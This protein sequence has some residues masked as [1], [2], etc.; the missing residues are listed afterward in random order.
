MELTLNQKQQLSQ[1]Q[2][3]SIEI[4]QLS[5][6]ELEQYLQTLAEENP[7][8]ELEPSAPVEDSAQTD[9]VYRR[10]EWL[11]END[12][13]NRCYRSA[14][15]EELEPFYQVG[16][17]GGLEETLSSF[18][19]R[20]LERLHLDRSTRELVEYLIYCLDEDGYFRVPLAELAQELGVPMIRLANAL[21]ILRSL[22]PAGVGAESLAQCLELQL[23]RA[24]Y[25]GPA[26]DIVRYH[27]DSLSRHHYREIA[28][29]LNLS[30]EEVHAAV[31]VIRDLEPKPGGI[32][33]AEEP[34]LYIQPDIYV[35]EVEGR[36]TVR[37]RQER[38]STFQISDY[39]R[40]LYAESPDA[41]TK[42]YLTKKLRQADYVL[43]ALQRR[44]STI[45]RCA[46]AIVDHQQ[47]FF[48]QGTQALHPLLMGDIARELKL[49]ESTVSRAIREKYLQCVH[50]V[51]PLRCFF[52]NS[53]V[54]TAGEEDAA[55]P[56]AAKLLLRKLISQEDSTH[57]L[58]DQK[59]AD[60]M[61]RLGCP[62]SRRTVSKY[63]EEMN[64]PGMF[65]RKTN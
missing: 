61:A 18:L 64:I 57:P 7:V 9:E 30:V 40:R 12:Y 50:G 1:Q 46:Q 41:E 36:L 5:A 13:Q 53:A 43:T 49:S 38:S 22:E 2:I 25:T 21:N 42:D 48:R 39:Y 35:E 6:L 19:Q 27:L 31:E 47:D 28:S 16:T 56:A 60:Q 8:V 32:F 23:V 3:Q 65:G 26:L 63:R 14:E 59:I 17:A 20:Q 37:P 29:R 11:E 51:F 54:S 24:K 10:L 34:V 55:S 4:L 33:S 45:Q 52:A 15:G 62:I 58:S 44:E